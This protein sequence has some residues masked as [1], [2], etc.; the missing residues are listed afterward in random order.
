MTASLNPR[1][2]LL[3]LLPP[4]RGLILAVLTACAFTG[5]AV[6]SVLAQPSVFPGQRLRVT[7]NNGGVVIGMVTA[8]TE[9]QS[10]TLSVD[11]VTGGDQG[12]SGIFVV[13]TGGPGGPRPEAE[14]QFG[15]VRFVEVSGGHKSG[16]LRGAKYGV[17]AGGAVGAVAALTYWRDC[18]VFC[19]LYGGIS[20]GLSGLAYGHWF[21]SGEQWTIMPQIGFSRG[22]GVRGVGVRLS[23]TTN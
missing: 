20:G 5:P 18:L 11:P 9:S 3:A 10:M 4:S 15:D 21:L 14:I 2:V 8:V 17:I 16:A 13:N 1:D 12:L 23:L 19:A 6:E 7:L 22:A